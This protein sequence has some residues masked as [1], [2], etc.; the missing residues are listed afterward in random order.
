[1]APWQPGNLETGPDASEVGRCRTPHTGGPGRTRAPCAPLA[2]RLAAGT[3]RRS[4]SLSRLLDSA[5]VLPG[6]A[7]CGARRRGRFLVGGVGDKVTGFSCADPAMERRARRP[8]PER[9][10]GQA[11]AIVG[12]NCGGRGGGAHAHSRLFQGLSPVRWRLRQTPT[13]DGG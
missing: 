5:R 13:E 12:G 1:L 6:P 7:V 8:G 4:S 9:S 11:H 10:P 2:G 3:W